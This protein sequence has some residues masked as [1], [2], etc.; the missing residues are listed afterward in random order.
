MW[1]C[2]NNTPSGSK[3]TGSKT[4]NG[5]GL[6]DMHGNVY[7]WAWDWYGLY[8]DSDA[9]DPTG[10]DSGA[11]RVTRGGS[12]GYGSRYSRSANR[13]GAWPTSKGNSIGFRLARTSDEIFV[14]GF[15]SGDTTLWTQTVP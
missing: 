5:Y 7:E 8:P 4:S 12:Y 9:T 13:I 14:D 11:V 3:V 15:E 1:W 6:F 2:G 10:P